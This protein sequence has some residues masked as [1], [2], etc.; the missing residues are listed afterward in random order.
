[1]LSTLLTFVDWVSGNTPL[2]S[3]QRRESKYHN[4]SAEQLQARK[5]YLEARRLKFVQLHQLSPKATNKQ[6]VT[7]KVAYVQKSGENVAFKLTKKHHVILR[8]DGTW[9]FSDVVQETL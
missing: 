6:L 4:M 2:N 8:R 9:S 7:A 5:D 1:M 3:K